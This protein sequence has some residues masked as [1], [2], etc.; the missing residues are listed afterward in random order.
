MLSS[1]WLAFCR[2]D[3]QRYRRP[4]WRVSRAAHFPAAWM[5]LHARQ[6][7]LGGCHVELSSTWDGARVQLGCCI[8]SKA[9]AGL[10]YFATHSVPG[11]RLVFC[12]PVKRGTPTFCVSDIGV[13][14]IRGWWR[15]RQET[16]LLICRASAELM[17]WLGLATKTTRWELLR[18]Y[19]FV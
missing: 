18:D 19:D 5:F 9:T 4:P 1:R 7:L 8:I 3:H 10:P 16:F 14:N 6:D 15:Q 12:S 11:E 2:A 17:V 13:E